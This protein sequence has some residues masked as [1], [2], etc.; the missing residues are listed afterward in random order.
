[1]QVW[2]VYYE[3][4]LFSEDLYNAGLSLVD[5]ES[6]TRIKRFFRREDACRTLIGRLLPRMMLRD[7]GVLPRAITFGA[8][9][10]RKPYIITPILDP[11]VA[12]N[13]SHDNGL[14]AMV[15]GP[16]TANPPAYTIGIDVMKVRI[17]GRE[18]FRS[19]VETVGDQASLT[20]LERR[21]LLSP[22]VSQDEALRRF[23]WIWTI[24]EAYT[25]ALGL[26]L[27]FD[28]NRVEFDVTSD[29]IR[30]DGAVPPGWQFRKFELVQGQDV[31]LGVVAEFTGG[32]ETVITSENEARPWL[33]TYDAHLFVQRAVREL[34]TEEDTD[35]IL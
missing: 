6:A 32:T 16:G 8:T 35:C 29:I 15:F 28:F 20:A 22:E 21:C 9:E 2:A 12:F 30:I 1:M 18:S 10:A 11:P 31:Y 19:F 3:P 23:F 33:V 26:G 4:A 24:K 5:P 7:H 13:V 27:G 25:K 34:Q 14:V 17:P